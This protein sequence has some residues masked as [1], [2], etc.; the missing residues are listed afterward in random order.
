[1]SCPLS[2]IALPL[3]RLAQTR[4]TVTSTKERHCPKWIL[5]CFLRAR[6]PES[7]SASRQPWRRNRNVFFQDSLERAAT[8]QFM[9]DEGSRTVLDYMKRVNQD[10][11]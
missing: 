2:C 11:N 4:T 10:Q 5:G 1:M 8:M 6:T 3:P 9:D 7:S